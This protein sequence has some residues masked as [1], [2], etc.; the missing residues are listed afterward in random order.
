MAP[1]LPRR[2][3]HA[4]PRRARRAARRFWRCRPRRSRPAGRPL[5]P[6][7]VC[8]QAVPARQSVAVVGGGPGRSPRIHTSSPSPTSAFQRCAIST[9]MAWACSGRNQENKMP[10]LSNRRST[11]RT[12]RARPA[13]NHSWPG[14]T[15]FL[16]EIPA[17]MALAGAPPQVSACANA[18]LGLFKT[19]LRRR[20]RGRGWPRTRPPAGGGA[21]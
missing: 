7:P 10:E 11:R 21:L 8:P 6:Q 4:G 18:R 20:A 2:C 5:L 17:T 14:S 3:D 9:L 16:D 12:R 1:T 15:L 19:F 13:L